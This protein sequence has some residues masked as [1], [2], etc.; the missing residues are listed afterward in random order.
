[1]QIHRWELERGGVRKNYLDTADAIDAYADAGLEE[2]DP[3]TLLI[4][5]KPWLRFW[6]DA[7]VPHHALHYDGGEFQE[8]TGEQARDCL[9]AFVAHRKFFR[10]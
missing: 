3:V 5:G 7:G 9:R 6:I 4:D 1:M 2:R 10:E 8:Y